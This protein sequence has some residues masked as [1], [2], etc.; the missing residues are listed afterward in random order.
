MIILSAID[1]YGKFFLIRDDI[2]WSEGNGEQGFNKKNTGYVDGEGAPYPGLDEK[3]LVLYAYLNRATEETIQ[4]VGIEGDILRQPS[5]EPDYEKVAYNFKVSIV[6]D[7][8]YTVHAYLFDV[9]TY[10]GIY[11]DMANTAVVDARTGEV[12]T[13]PELLNIQ[14]VES[15]TEHYFLTPNTER[16]LNDKIGELTDLGMKEGKCSKRYK[17]LLYSNNFVDTQ[18]SGAHVRFNDGYRY[19]AQEIIEDLT[20]TDPYEFC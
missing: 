6:E 10:E 20:A 2:G 17:E 15:K 3:V 18:L 5:D 1:Q 9:D 8:W 19:S 16:L 12:L 4:E 13:K 11:Y 7:G 14:G